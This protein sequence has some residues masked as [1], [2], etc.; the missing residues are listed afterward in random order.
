MVSFSF[1]R[2]ILDSIE[3]GVWKN[4][5]EIFFIFY[6][7]VYLNSGD[8]QIPV[9]CQRNGSP[10]CSSIDEARNYFRSIIYPEDPPPCG[11]V[12]ERLFTHFLISNEFYEILSTRFQGLMRSLSL[13]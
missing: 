11:K 12:L 4:Q 5:Q 8:L 3:N 13:L 2:D 7:D 10:L 1:L 9:Q 6:F